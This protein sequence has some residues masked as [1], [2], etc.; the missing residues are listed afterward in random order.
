MCLHVIGTKKPAVEPFTIATYRHPPP[1]VRPANQGGR[2]RHRAKEPPEALSVVS[3]SRPVL[4]NHNR[5]LGRG[6]FSDPIIFFN[7]TDDMSWIRLSHCDLR[8]DV[9]FTPLIGCL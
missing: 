7:V 6:N 1:H 5:L 2:G 8:A 3:R 9:I 4:A